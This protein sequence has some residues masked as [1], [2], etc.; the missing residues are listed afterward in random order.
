[1]KRLILLSLLFSPLTFAFEGHFKINPYTIR[2]EG[3]EVYLKFQ[4]KKTTRL[5]ITAYTEN[6]ENNTSMNEDILARGKKLKSIKL[7]KQNCNDSLGY[8]ISFITRNGLVEAVN[9]ELPQFACQKEGFTFGFLSD[10]QQ[11]TKKHQKVATIVKKHLKNVNFILHTGDVVHTGANN[12]EWLNYFNV[13]QAY[14]KGVPLIAAIGNHSYY[15]KKENPLVPNLFNRY[16]RWKGSPKIG[17]MTAIFPTFQLVIINSNFDKIKDHFED[18]INWLEDTLRAA[19]REGR[20]VIVGMHHPPFAASITNLSKEMVIMREKFV[21]LFEKYGVKLVLNGHT[22]VY[23][24]SFKNG[25]HYVI[26]G[27]AGGTRAIP[28]GVNPNQVFIKFLA[29]TFSTITVREKRIELNT[30][31]QKD[32]KIDQL[33]IKL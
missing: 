17:F 32:K 14:L 23:E 24:R 10:T 3:G 29:M 31:D 22:H 7:G 18:Q 2:A 9:R 12:D 4:L 28:L 20:S 27:P 8:K 13:A 16:L 33:I 30:W 6:D 26:A 21:P 19:N 5:N 15:G 25:V 1:M 11:G